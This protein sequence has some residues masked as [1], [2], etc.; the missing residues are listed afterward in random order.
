[1]KF[2]RIYLPF[3]SFFRCKKHKQASWTEYIMIRKG[4]FCLFSPLFGV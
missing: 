1:M 3:Y 4:Y 2:P